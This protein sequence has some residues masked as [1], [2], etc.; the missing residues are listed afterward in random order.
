MHS[1]IAVFHSS[2]QIQDFFSPCLTGKCQ[3]N[4]RP[5][6][7]PALRLSPP[8][9]Q[10][11]RSMTGARQ[12]IAMM[13][14]SRKF[15]KYSLERRTGAYNSSGIKESILEIVKS[16]SLFLVV[17]RQPQLCISL[18]LCHQVPVFT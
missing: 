11:Y 10:V 17:N 18:Q 2:Q 16:T 12:T 14:T 7:L 3:P 8:I 9:G 4:A 6:T 5:D 13:A 1:F 15:N